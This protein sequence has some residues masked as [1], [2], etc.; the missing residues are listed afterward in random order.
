M[1]YYVISSRIFNLFHFTLYLICIR[2]LIVLKMM[3][4][5]RNIFLSHG[6]RCF[7]QEH[8][9]SKCPANE[10]RRWSGGLQHRDLLNGIVRV[11]N[12]F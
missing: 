8:L 9:V 12:K 7:R 2:L 4:G 1:M 3:Y 5:N 6:I 11:T 10:V